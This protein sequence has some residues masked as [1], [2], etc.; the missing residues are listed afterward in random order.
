MK[1]VRAFV[2]VLGLVLPLG[3]AVAQPVTFAYHDGTGEGYLDQLD[4]DNAEALRITPEH[5]VTLTAIRFAATSAGPVELHVWAD[6][7]GLQPDVE[8]DLVTPFSVEAVAG[9]MVE[10]AIPGDGIVVDV[11]QEI[12]VGIVHAEA[13]PALFVDGHEDY[14]PRSSIYAYS[15]DYGKWLWFGLEGTYMVEVD[16]VYEDVLERTWF[17][18]VSEDAGLAGLGRVSWPDFDNDG[19]PDLCSGGGVLYRNEGDGTFTDVTEAAGIGGFGAS[20]GVWADYD[21]DGDL[22]LYAAVSSFESEDPETHDRLWRNEGDGTF[23][24]VSDAA[25]APYDDFPTQ[26]AAWGDF[27]GDGWIDLYVANYEEPGEELSNGTPDILWRNNGDGTFSD[28]TAAAGLEIDP[29]L[30]GRGV[31]W[32]DFD[33][34]F[35]LDFYV[36]NY[37]LD[38]NL[39][40]VNQ[41]DGTFVDEALARGVQGYKPLMQYAWGHTIGSVWGDLDNDGDLDLVAANLAHPRFIEFSDKTMVLRNEGAPDWTFTD[42]QPSSGIA[43]A[44]THSN[45]TMGD[46]DN[47]GDLDVHITCVYAGRRSFLYRNDGDFHFTDVNYPSGLYIDGGW[48]SAWADYDGD[49]DLDFAAKALYENTLGDVG[50][51]GHWLAIRLEGTDSNRAAIGAQIFVEAGGRLFVRSVSGGT[52]TGCQPPLV[53]H[54]GLGGA[55]AVE[56]IEVRWPSGR[57]ESWDELVNVDQRFTL[58]EGDLEAPAWEGPPPVLEPATDTVGGLGHGRGHGGGLGHRLGPGHRRGHRLGLGHGLGFGRGSGPVHGRREWLRRG[59]V[60]GRHAQPPDPPVLPAPRAPHGPR[61]AAKARTL[62]RVPSWGPDV[63]PSKC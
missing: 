44:E 30:C 23:T 34:D 17:N 12:F 10:A 58:T 16:G 63:A 59:P 31:A 56:R 57:T 22:D 60:H 50:E 9:E 14:E 7:G 28:A 45:A 24:D 13:E 32:A 21:N 48:G 61:F 35:D 62:I 41:G 51:A 38:P 29:L 39:L 6:N 52:G 20:G 40:W 49:G 18:D 26:A 54:F 27:D 37:R 11:P 4:A 5:P 43:Y 15:A 1:L 2:L 33:Q 36:S 8:N 46:Y 19:D 55:P 25:G 3:N 42:L 53:Q 47:D